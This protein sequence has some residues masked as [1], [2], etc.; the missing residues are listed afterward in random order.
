MLFRSHIDTHFRCQNGNASFNWRLIFPI[1]LSTTR[2]NNTLTLQ[3][4]D[5]DIFSP[6]DYIGSC[7]LDMTKLFKDAFENNRS[8][9]WDENYNHLVFGDDPNIKLKF[10]SETP[11]GKYK[12]KFWLPMRSKDRNNPEEVKEQG[13]ILISV[14][15]FTK[16]E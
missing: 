16:S 13:S 12:T 10:D 4:W 11:E 15:L 5:K 3:A 1:T 7:S 9:T 6:N 14:Q 2:V 8:V